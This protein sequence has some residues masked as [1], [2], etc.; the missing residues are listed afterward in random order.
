MLEA[1]QACADYSG[2]AQL[3]PELYRTVAKDV[4]GSTTLRLANG[5]DYDIGGEWA[6]IRLFDVACGVLAKRPPR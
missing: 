6:H 4:F 1:Y 3:S 5:T 2:M